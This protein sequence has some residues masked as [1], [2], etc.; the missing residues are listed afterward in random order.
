MRGH[1]DCFHLSPAL[2]LSAPQQAPAHTHIHF[3]VAD[4]ATRVL[5]IAS[6]ILSSE[7]TAENRNSCQHPCE[8]ST[9]EW[10]VLEPSLSTGFLLAFSCP[11][12]CRNPISSS[13]GSNLSYHCPSLCRFVV[14]KTY[15][16]RTLPSLEKPRDSPHC[17]RDTFLRTNSLKVLCPSVLLLLG[18]SESECLENRTVG[19]RRH[20]SKAR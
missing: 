18:T 9:W 7:T 1:C 12:A 8:P 14:F 2:G 6:Q 19:E 17:V 11:R 15:S 13:C 20:K 16:Q 5:Q 10:A 3:P 4:R